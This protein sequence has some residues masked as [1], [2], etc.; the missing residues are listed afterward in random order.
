VARGW[1]PTPLRK[2]LFNIILSTI[3]IVKTN[4]EITHSPHACLASQCVRAMPPEDGGPF[5]LAWLVFALALAN[6]VLRVL[7]VALAPP[8]PRPIHGPPLK[9]LIVLG[10][11]GHTAEMFALLRWLP[12]TRYAPRTYVIADTDTT[13]MA[14]V[15]AHEAEIAQRYARTDEYGRGDNGQIRVDTMTS[16]VSS[17]ETRLPTHF[18]KTHP[19]SREVGQSYAS[20]I[21]TTLN[22]TAHAVLFF[23]TATFF[24]SEKPDVVLVNGPGTCLPICAAAFASRVLF[25]R[26]GPVIVYVESVCRVTSLS[27]TGKILY[28]SRMADV[29]FVQWPELVAKYHRAMYAGRVV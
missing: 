4:N 6:L 10:S 16:D 18:V 29:V 14:K 2:R 3:V 26:K 7:F 17:L 9:T 21:F 5:V 25:F 20:S 11:G 24:T 27:L 23:V 28:H 1:C 22:A 13:S 8:K 12:P 19:R 15:T